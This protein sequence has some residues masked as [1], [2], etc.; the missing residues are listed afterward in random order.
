M[1]SIGLSEA[2]RLTGRNQSTIHRA[3]KTGQLSY[4]KDEAG[5]RRIDTAEL[6]RVFGIKN[7]APERSSSGNGA[8][9]ATDAPPVASQAAHEPES[10]RIIAAQRE[11]IEQQD[12]TIRD[13][14]ARLD[15][16]SAERRREVEE[17]RQLIHLLTDQRARQPWWR[18]WF[19]S[20]CSGTQR[21]VGKSFRTTTLGHL[22]KSGELGGGPVEPPLPPDHTSWRV[23]TFRTQR[24][25]R[26]VLEHAAPAGDIPLRVCRFFFGLRQRFDIGHVAGPARDQPV[27]R[28][29]GDRVAVAL[30]RLVVD[31]LADAMLSDKHPVHPVW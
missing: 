4:A 25:G 23:T 31:A 27:L 17:R 10:E 28:L 21:H 16:E 19:R 24:P 18:R 2:A 7:F 15:A 22:A 14:R 30:Q 11:T 8:S 12:A 13:L 1:A 6:D 20:S 26:G 29:A 3:M 9:L 5:G